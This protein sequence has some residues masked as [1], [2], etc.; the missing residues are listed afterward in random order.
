MNEPRVNILEVKSKAF[1][2]RI[3][4]LYQYLRVQKE[5]VLSKQIL[6]SGTSIGA[7]IAEGK[8]A[9][10][11][12]DFINKNSIALKE[13]SETLYWLDLLIESRMLD[14]FDATEFLK[15]DCE[16]LIRILVASIKT[17]KGK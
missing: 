8:Y 13:A 7:N 14:G 10:S 12:D 1:A 5:S 15:N 4:K 6:R 16:E 3:I 9:Q 17:A 11:K 2:L